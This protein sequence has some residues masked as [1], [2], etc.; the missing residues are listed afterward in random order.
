MKRIILGAIAAVMC[1][2]TVGCE[3]NGGNSGDYTYTLE[4]LSSFSETEEG[5]TTITEY[6]W[7]DDGSMAGQK[8]TRGGQ[9]IY[10]DD[11]FTYKDRT[12]TSY[13]T[14]YEGGSV[15]SRVKIEERY[16]YATWTGLYSTRIYNEEGELIERNEN[17]YTDGYQSGYEHEK[18][19]EMLLERTDYNYDLNTVSYV[20]SGTTVEGRQLVK[21]TYFA[22]DYTKVNEIVTSVYDSSVT[23]IISRKKYSYSE[24]GAYTGY[25][26]Y[27]GDTEQVVEEQTDYVNNSNKLSYTTTWYDDSGLQIRRV[28]T[29]QDKITL[30]ITIKY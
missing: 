12:I 27:R 19:G 18:N 26:V 25:K 4:L 11:D 10:Q 24:N 23:S 14:Y 16:N 28:T 22:L 30:T 20:E 5:V 2:S 3:M 15:S 6:K 21:I 9:L 7:N 17:I 13:R 29:I 1:L 8:Q